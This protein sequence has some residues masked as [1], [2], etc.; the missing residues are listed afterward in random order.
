[1]P[2]ASATEAPSPTATEIAWQ[3]LEVAGPAAREDHT[4]TVNGRGTTA[5]LF[6]GR[7]ADGTAFSD[8]WAFD[9]AT[10]AWRRLEVAGPPARFG[11]NAV[12]V[13]GMGLVVFA[14]Q[15]PAGFFDDL[16]L[17][18]PA[19]ER[20]R[21]LPG[22]GAR[23]LARYGSCAALSSDGRL[24]ISHG[25]TSD[26]SRFSDT[27]TYDFTTLRWQDVTPDSERP[28]ERCLHACWWT[29]DGR[30]ALYG[31]QT[32]GVPA[33]GDLWLLDAAEPRW[34]EV[35]L[36]RGP[37]ARQL[38]AS[39]R[40][41]AGTVVVGGGTL[42]GNYLADGWL[43]A[44]DGSARPLDTGDGPAPRSGAEL[45]PDPERQRLLLFGGRDGGGAFDDTWSLELPDG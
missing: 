16:W 24:W 5:Y 6:G 22:D 42:D 18:E 12:W 3:R 34:Q 21:Q 10:D 29:D 33:L 37:D 36:D 15:S 25:F 14:G 27:R 39:A 28:V 2:T 11:H 32:T 17:F 30:L 44:D 35:T 41:G 31:G 38:Y 7:A 43:I 20:W 4:W 19:A 40:W 9:L 1:M 23:P 26:G 13:D 45:I 8:L